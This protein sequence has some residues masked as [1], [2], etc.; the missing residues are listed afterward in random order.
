[1]IS[2]NK[3]I[4]FTAVCPHC[5]KETYVA[6]YNGIKLNILAF[7][8]ATITCNICNNKF[9]IQVEAIANKIQE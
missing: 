5:N 7:N 2:S 3:V 8:D 1:M 4:T 9:T 6:S